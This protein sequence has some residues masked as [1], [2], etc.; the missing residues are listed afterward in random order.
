MA[1]NPLELSKQIKVDPIDRL[2][3]D[4]HQKRYLKAKYKGADFDTAIERLRGGEGYG[5]VLGGLVTYETPT[6]RDRWNKYI[7]E[8]IGSGD[9]VDYWNQELEDIETL[10]P[11][12]DQKEHDT[13]LNQG[14]AWK[15]EPEW[16]DLTEQLIKKYEGGK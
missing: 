3:L 16:L 15:G 11:F 10:L 9:N 5:D 2:D 7:N 6:L 8:G 12:K 4:D 1:K 13:W 14:A